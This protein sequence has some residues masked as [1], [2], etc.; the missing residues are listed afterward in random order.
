MCRWMQHIRSTCVLTRAPRLGEGRFRPVLYPQRFS[1]AQ[2]PE[3]LATLES[4]ASY[5]K[6]LVIP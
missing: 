6:V 4:R 3:A 1:L 5:G 2:V